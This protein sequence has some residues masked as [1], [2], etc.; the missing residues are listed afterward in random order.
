MP[1]PTYAKIVGMPGDLSLGPGATLTFAMDM[2]CTFVGRRLVIET[3]DL[4]TGS[5]QT[6]MI[7][8]ITHDNNELV[9]NGRI[10]LNPNTAFPPPVWRFE[11][12]AA[13]SGA[14]TATD[15]YCEFHEHFE[16]GDLFTV[17]LFNQTAN[18]T[19]NIIY[20]ITNY[21]EACGCQKKRK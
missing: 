5:N 6:V 2:P 13:G 18:N 9:A 15:T 12:S 20:W 7:R 4:A 17:T 10:S 14:I 1:S 8:S 21:G 16:V 19:Q 11:P 3:I